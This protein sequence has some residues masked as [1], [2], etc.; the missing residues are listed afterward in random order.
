MIDR[1]VG[2]PNDPGHLALETPDTLRRTRIPAQKGRR[3]KDRYQVVVIGGGIVGCSVLYHLALRGCTDT[4]LI[5]R[6]ELTAGSTLS[7]R[8]AASTP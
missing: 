8:P 7:T 2:D 1:A 4:P 6:E 3:V 5:E